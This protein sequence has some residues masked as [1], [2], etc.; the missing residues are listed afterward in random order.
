MKNTE[1]TF[2]QHNLLEFIEKKGGSIRTTEHEDLDLHWEL[3][4][5]GY[6]RNLVCL[7]TG[8]KFDLTDK[9]TEYLRA[10]TQNL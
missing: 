6:L 4:R 5:A 7:P 2:L 9:G 1:P 3:V 10:I 8:W